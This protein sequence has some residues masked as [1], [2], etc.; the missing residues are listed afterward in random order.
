MKSLR[1]LSIGR[2]LTHLLLLAIGFIWMYPF[3]WMIGA[4]FKAQPEFFG[5]RLSL[6]P[7]APTFE[8]IERIWSKANFNTYFLNTVIVTIVSV[9]LVLIMTSSA[10]YVM[11]RYRFVGKKAITA[12]FVASISIPLVSTIIPVYEVVKSMGLVGNIWGLI[13]SGAGGAHV[14][15]LLLFSS[16]YQQLPKEMEEAARIDGCGFLRTYLKVMMPLAS[17]IATTVVIMETIWTWNAFLLP[18]VL[19]LNN[20]SSRTLAVGLYAFRGENTVDWTGIAAGGTISVIPIIILFIAMQ[21]RFV[22]GVAGAV[23]S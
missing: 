10:G 7:Q 21:K 12:L 22:E 20:P 16:Y 14:V 2:S 13:L 19:T 5:N 6:L 8:N 23:K 3:L 17:P 15:F 11:G 4:S 18:L 1:K 9:T